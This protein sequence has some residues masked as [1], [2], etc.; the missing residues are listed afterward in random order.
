MNRLWW[1]PRSIACYWRSSTGTSAPAILTPGE[2]CGTARASPGVWQEYWAHWETHFDL[3]HDTRPFYQ[4][5][6]ITEDDEPRTTGILEFHR[7]SGNNATLVDHT[8]DDRPPVMAAAEIA[9]ALVTHQTFALGGTVGYLKSSEKDADKRAS[10]APSARGAI[11]LLKGA[12]LFQTL[13]LNLAEYNPG[14]NP[15]DLPCW[16][17]AQSQGKGERTPD[18]RLD[19]FTWLG[20]APGVRQTVKTLFTVR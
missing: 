15:K 3:F 20:W 11:C 13:M 8:T 12:S 16:E 14:A 4:S 10:D 5:A 7:S 9:R 2:Y 1:L 17:R 6:A 18:G 19:L